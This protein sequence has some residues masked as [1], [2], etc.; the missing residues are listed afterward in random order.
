MYRDNLIHIFLVREGGLTFYGGIFGAI[1]F[2]V[3]YIIYKKYSLP[4]LFDVC[5]PAI[6]LGYSIARIGCF[7]NGCC[8]GRV[9]PF[10]VFP[11]G[12]HFPSLDGWRFPTQI[13]SAGYSLLILFL[14]LKL[15]RRKI[16]QGELFFDYLWLY[17]IARFLIEYL[18]EEPFSVF[19]IMTAAQFACLLILVISL[20]LREI[21]KKHA[22][23]RTQNRS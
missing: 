17:A 2:A 5:T 6:A 14:L 1:L 13:Y 12:V 20:I 11:L 21:L 19:G 15:E 10:S 3:P 23:Q 22:V 4:A 8:Y 7:L 9:S 16:F 18:R